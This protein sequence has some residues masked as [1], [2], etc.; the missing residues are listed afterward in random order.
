MTIF[1]F[2]WTN[3]LFVRNFLNLFFIG[4][5]V[6]IYFI[7]KLHHSMIVCVW[8]FACEWIH[9]YVCMCVGS[10]L[11][12]ACVS[13]FTKQILLNVLIKYFL[14]MFFISSCDIIFW[15]HH[16]KYLYR[17][18][19]YRIF[20]KTFLYDIFV[21][22][23]L[24]EFFSYLQEGTAIIVSVKSRKYSYTRDCFCSHS[25]IYEEWIFNDKVL[26]SC[27]CQHLLLMHNA[28][29]KKIFLLRFGYENKV[30]K[31]RLGNGPMRYRHLLSRLIET[32]SP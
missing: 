10:V 31:Y 3:V 2:I 30:N 17:I 11:K 27:T 7:L 8:L 22:K 6:H 20:V 1:Q 26:G 13:F 9:I 4:I 21:A 24:H 28:W 12:G 29:C 19:F 18:F 15:H 14:G 25:H 16:V 23:C 5:L 32:F